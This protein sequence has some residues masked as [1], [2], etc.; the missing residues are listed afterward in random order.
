[1][2]K[3]TGKNKQFF[4]FYSVIQ[5]FDIKNNQKYEKE[6]NQIKFFVDRECT[7][8]LN[9]IVHTRNKQKKHETYF[10]TKAFVC[11]THLFI[12]YI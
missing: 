4:I 9:L 6:K 8:L 1:M 3:Q 2:G 5:N 12:Y 10:R 11:V 7:K